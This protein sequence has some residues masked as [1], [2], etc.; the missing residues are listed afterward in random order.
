MTFKITDGVLELKSLRELRGP[1]TR[2]VLTMTPTTPT[3]SPSW[4]LM[5][6]WKT[7]GVLR[8]ERAVT[9]NVTNV[10]EAGLIV[11]STLQPQ[12]EIPITATIS[13]PDNPD[14]TNT[15]LTDLGWEWLRGQD[16]IAGATG[17]TYTPMVTDVGSVLTARAS[18]EDVEGE[19]KT[20]EIESAH[21]VRAKP[22]NNT[23][24]AFPDQDS[25]TPGNQQTRTGGGKYARG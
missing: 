6:P 18:Y 5:Q 22:D 3:R 2:L 9:V 14:L 10:E 19:D 7:P 15:P 20:A 16:V 23:P 4:P 25:S 12:V 8:D 1:T 21:A 11:L 24:P 13:D 17:A